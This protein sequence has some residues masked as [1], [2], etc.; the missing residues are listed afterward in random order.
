M[1]LKASQSQCQPEAKPQPNIKKRRACYPEKSARCCCVHPRARQN[2]FA[3]LVECEAGKSTLTDLSRFLL[4]NILM[5]FITVTAAA[6][7]PDQENKLRDQPRLP[8]ENQHSGKQNNIG[9]SASH[10]RTCKFSLASA[11]NCHPQILK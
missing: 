8:H 2:F 1:Q 3:G 10:L 5:N 4:S 6:V 7:L 11:Q 9:Q